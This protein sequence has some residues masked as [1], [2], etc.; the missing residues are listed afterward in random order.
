MLPKEIPSGPILDV[1]QRNSKWRNS[2]CYPKKF[3]VAQFLMLPKE[4]PSGAILYVTQRN[5]KWRNS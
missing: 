2:L 1:T 4:I 3:Q 5:S